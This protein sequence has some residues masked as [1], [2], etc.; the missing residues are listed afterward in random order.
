LG[1]IYSVVHF[2]VSKDTILCSG[3]K[4]DYTADS[5]TAAI[6][7]VSGIELSVFSTGL[8]RAEF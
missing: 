1:R 3:P 8:D 5:E 6:G 2:S 7:R 4:R